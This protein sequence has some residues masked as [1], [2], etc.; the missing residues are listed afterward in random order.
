[1]QH[2]QLL[3]HYQKKKIKNNKKQKPYY[4]SKFPHIPLKEFLCL[5]CLANQPSIFLFETIFFTG[6]IKEGVSGHS[7]QLLALVPPLVQMAVLSRLQ[8]NNKQWSCMVFI[9]HKIASNWGNSAAIWQ[10]ECMATSK[11]LIGPVMW[12][13]ELTKSSSYPPASTMEYAPSPSLPWIPLTCGR[14]IPASLTW[15]Q[16]I[17]IIEYC[18]IIIK[19]I[20]IIIIIIITIIITFFNLRTF[21]FC[22]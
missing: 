8:K 13:T 10:A 12:V 9:S 14:C 21:L 17:I 18:T 15:Q 3:Q 4:Y 22:N 1:M 16:T 5:K 20:I 11:V 19:I 7:I 2:R 6:C